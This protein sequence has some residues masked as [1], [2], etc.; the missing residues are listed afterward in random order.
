MPFLRNDDILEDPFSSLSQG[1]GTQADFDAIFKD[2]A[3]PIT[4]MVEKQDGT[5]VI[6]RG[7]LGLTLVFPGKNVNS[8]K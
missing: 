8:A 7:M 1:G 6:F 5:L 3:D 2:N 4:A